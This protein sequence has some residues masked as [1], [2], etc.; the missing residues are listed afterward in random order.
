[1]RRLTRATAEWADEHLLAVGIS[2]ALVGVG[3]LWLFFDAYLAPNGFSQRVEAIK[4]AQSLAT[5]AAVVIGG[6]WAYVKVVRRREHAPRVD[7][8]V[9][10]GFVGRQ[11][12]RW[13]IE[14]R[15]LINNEGLVRHTCRELSFDLR[16]LFEADALIDGDATIGGQ[17]L[18]PHVVAHASWLPDDWDETFIEPGLR[19]R[20][21]YVTSLPDHASFV[22]L[23]GFLA[24][25]DG[26]VVHTAECLLKVPAAEPERPRLPVE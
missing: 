13:L 20:Y 7:F 15:A 17:T 5:F 23:H 22:L 26:R 6:I 25:G 9:D 16:C 4:A 24:Y 21:S 3:A 12:Q 11:Q 1:V 10:V 8:T 2:A 14:V 18:V 19:T